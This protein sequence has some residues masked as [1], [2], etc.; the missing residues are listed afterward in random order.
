MGGVVFLL[1]GIASLLPEAVFSETRLSNAALF[2]ILP[3]GSASI[4]FIDDWI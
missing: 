3:L 2:W 1:I 4:G